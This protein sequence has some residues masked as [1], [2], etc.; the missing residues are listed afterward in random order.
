VSRLLAGIKR[1]LWVT[2]RDDLKQHGSRLLER[3]TVQERPGKMTLR[4]WQE[5]SGFDRNLFTV[6]AVTASLDYIH[7]NPVKRGLCHKA[8]GWRLSP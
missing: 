2:V 7:T 6:K 3:L 5:G 8:R 4:F 1:P